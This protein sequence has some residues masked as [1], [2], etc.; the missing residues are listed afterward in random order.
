M[1]PIPVRAGLP[2]LYRALSYGRPACQALIAPQA[3]ALAC[4]GR[5]RP[6]VQQGRHSSGSLEQQFSA[7]VADFFQ[8][9]DAAG[10]HGRRWN[11]R[12]SE[13][14]ARPLVLPMQGPLPGDDEVDIVLAS[15]YRRIYGD[16]MA[17]WYWCWDW[18]HHQ[19]LAVAWPQVGLNALREGIHQRGGVLA[20]AK[21]LCMEVASEAMQDKTSSWLALIEQQSLTLVRQHNG[22]WQDWCVTPLHDDVEVSLPLQLAR[23][24]ARRQDD[25][26]VLTLVDLKG[27]SPVVALRQAL[28]DTGWSVRVWVCPAAQARTSVACRLTQA[29]AMGACA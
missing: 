2:A 23:E 4:G 11:V 8:L 26:R 29:I 18:Q 15:Q 3:V 28:T 13:Y 12:V 25:C 14:W 16:L 5:A 27:M 22:L 10:L 21:S 24:A 17:G 9:V 6:L 19:I 20:S 7:A 1:N